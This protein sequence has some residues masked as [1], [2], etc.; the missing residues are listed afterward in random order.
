MFDH[1]K[2][3]SNSIC[4]Q[5]EYDILYHLPFVCNLTVVKKQIYYTYNL[6][7]VKVSNFKFVFSE[8]YYVFFNKQ[9]RFSSVVV[10]LNMF[11]L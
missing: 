5:I 4:V 3:N 7:F 11:T 6:S 9:L 8:T 1:V 2:K 10:L